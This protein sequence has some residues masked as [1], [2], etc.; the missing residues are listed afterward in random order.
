MTDLNQARIEILAN[1]KEYEAA[2]KELA[3]ARRIGPVMG[4]ENAGHNLRAE[5]AQARLDA[6]ERNL[7]DRTTVEAALLGELQQLAAEYY[8]LKDAFKSALWDELEAVQKRDAAQQTLNYQ[9]RFSILGLDPI[10]TIRA[11][12]V[13]QDAMEKAIAARHAI[14]FRLDQVHQRTGTN[15]DLSLFPAFAAS[16]VEAILGEVYD[17]QHLAGVKAQ[18][19]ITDQMLA[20]MGTT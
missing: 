10:K 4:G 14:E 13:A 17:Q 20:R 6:I 11:V 3:I 2:Q 19:G 5:A 12:P 16:R 8:R 15:P 9:Q 1:L 7:P 18:F